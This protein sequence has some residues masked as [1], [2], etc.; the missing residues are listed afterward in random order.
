MDFKQINLQGKIIPLHTPKVMGILNITD[1]S[2]YD[3]GRYQ[4]KNE[5]GKRVEQM[6]KEGVDIIDLG[7][8]ST[9]P[10]VTYVDEDTEQ[11]K[12][13][14]TVVFLRENFGEIHISID[15]FRASVA[16]VGVEN[17]ACLINDVSAGLMDSEM[18]ATV[19]QL[20]VPYIG[21][22]MRG[23]SSNMQ[24]LTSYQHLLNDII[25][26][27]AERKQTVMAAGINDFIIDP[28]FGFAKTLDQNYELLQNLQQFKV[29]DC[30]IL[31]GLSRKSMIYKYLDISPEEALNGTTVLHTIALLK[32]ASILRVH[33]VKEAVETIKL[34]QKIA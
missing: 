33:D 21:M 20:G 9:K 34:I 24:H 23:D 27:F 12:V 18:I 22:H 30:P 6:L 19:A 26:Y 17:G 29:L 4:S 11:Q 25:L 2:F 10:G 15:T 16:K 13:A 3:G 1:N 5:I 8:C 31:V 28:G 7:A 14:D 32:G